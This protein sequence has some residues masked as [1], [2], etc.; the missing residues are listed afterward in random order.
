MKITIT[1]IPPEGLDIDFKGD[2]KWLEQYYG[3]S[4]KEISVKILESFMSRIHINKI[5]DIVKISGEAKVSTNLKCIRC[6]E[7]FEKEV[8]IVIK[9]EFHPI[10]EWISEGEDLYK[11]SNDEMEWEFYSEPFIEIEDVVAEN[12]FLTIPLYPLCKEDCRGLCKMCGTN[13]NKKSCSCSTNQS[14]E[15]WKQVL[16]ELTKK[17]KR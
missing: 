9:N 14:V 3:K 1:E 10:E 8:D 11:L 7:W 12:F 16:A 13:L 6:G 15:N 17:L 5:Q 4:E 2:Q